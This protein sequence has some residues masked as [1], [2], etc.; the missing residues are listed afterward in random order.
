VYMHKAC[1][2][3]RSPLRSKRACVED[4]VST[5]YT[6]QGEEIASV[7]C[8]HFSVTGCS[9]MVDVHRLCTGGALSRLVSSER[10]LV[11]VLSHSSAARMMVL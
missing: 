1:D 7:C 6:F 11:W 3:L 4:L 8:S 2:T 9:L 10:Y 5:P